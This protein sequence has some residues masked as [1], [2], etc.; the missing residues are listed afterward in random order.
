ME[1][2]L[3]IDQVDTE[4]CLRARSKGYRIFGVCGAVL[5][6]RLGE[7]AQRVWTGRWR[8]LPR[9]KPFR[10]YY[11]FRN[12]IL[13]CRR[14]YVPGRWVLF[15]LRWLV[16]LFITYGLLTRVR[17]GELGMMV[18]GAVDGVRGVTGKLK[19]G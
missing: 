3:F 7:T 17:T 6:H 9:H 5:E 10:Y 14:P 12:T 2:S 1:E 16:V 18:K 11:I 4:W 15:N 19:Q 13:L 8:R